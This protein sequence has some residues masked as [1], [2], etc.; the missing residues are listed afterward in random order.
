VLRTAG[1]RVLVLTPMRCA[2]PAAIVDVETR[3]Y[4]WMATSPLHDRR[5]VRE[6]V[7]QAE[8]ADQLRGGARRLLGARSIGEDAHRDETPAAVS[9]R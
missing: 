4:E 6:R 7:D 9:I 1:G 2:D 8:L 3:R 5:R